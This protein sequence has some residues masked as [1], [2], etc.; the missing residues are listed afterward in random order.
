[1]L[2]VEKAWAPDIWVHAALW[3]PLS[4]V[5]T[6]ATLPYIKGAVLV[7]MLQLRIH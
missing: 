5:L 1:M 2:W 4:L 7:L 6:L 3:V